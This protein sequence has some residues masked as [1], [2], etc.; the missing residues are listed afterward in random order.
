MALNL[1]K[2][3]YI[4]INNNSI[5]FKNL[6][7]HN[8]GSFD[9]YIIYKYLLKIIEYNKINALIDHQNKFISINLNLTTKTIIKDSYRIFPVS[10]QQLCQVFNIEGKLNNYN[11]E[12]NNINI[13][14]LI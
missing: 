12:Y 14:D 13:L 5:N 10:L 1:F 3:F 8:L 7:A 6:F 11:L 2:D 4:F 9:G